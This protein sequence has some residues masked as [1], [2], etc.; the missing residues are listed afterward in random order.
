MMDYDDDEGHDSASDKPGLRELVR[1]AIA[2]GLFIDVAPAQ[3]FGDDEQQLQFESVIPGEGQLILDA[4]SEGQ[5]N[6]RAAAT[7]VPWEEFTGRQAGQWMR[8]GGDGLWAL[9]EEAVVEALYAIAPCA[10]MTPM[11]LMR[12]REPSYDE[13]AAAAQVLRVCSGG[14]LSLALARRF[15][16]QRHGWLDWDDMLRT[17]RGHRR[18]GR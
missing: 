18:G 6:W 3:P 12:R 8:A 17:K 7:W 14:R 13:L 2:L 4:W 9:P 15:I 5:V 11:D 1:R 16:A 10:A